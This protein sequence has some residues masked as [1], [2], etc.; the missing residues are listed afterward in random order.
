M[1]LVDI[2]CFYGIMVSD[3]YRWVLQMVKKD[4]KVQNSVGL[5]SYPAT[6]FIQTAMK[7]KSSIWVERDTRRIDAKSLLG[8]LSLG[9]KG[10]DTITIG[11]DG[12]DEV[13]ALDAMIALVESGFAKN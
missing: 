2:D 8:V 1:F 12:A 13:E 7:F 3:Y 5:H 4:V 6:Y 9:V 10:G 11:A